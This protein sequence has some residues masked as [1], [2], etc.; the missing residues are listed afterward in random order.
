MNQ[1]KEIHRGFSDS[2]GDYVI[3]EDYGKPVILRR[4]F[5]FQILTS[6]SLKLDYRKVIIRPGTY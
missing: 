2:T 5:F 6:F 1:R 4:P 3:E